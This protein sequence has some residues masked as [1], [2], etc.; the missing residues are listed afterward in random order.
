[1]ASMEEVEER[2]LKI[3]QLAIEGFSTQE[4]ARLLKVSLR[5][6]QYDTK[7]IS[8]EIFDDLR[9]DSVERILAQFLLKYDSIYKEARKTYRETTNDNVKIGALNLMQKHEEAKIRIL[10]SLGFL[11]SAPEKIQ[12]SGDVNLSVKAALQRIQEREKEEK[13]KAEKQY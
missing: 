4:I 13:K 3:K 9:K 1:M 12:L 8:R 6:I 11:D 7:K 10:Q 5:T 2:R